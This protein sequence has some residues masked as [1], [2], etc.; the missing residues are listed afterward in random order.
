MIFFVTNPSNVPIPL[1]ASMYISY[2]TAKSEPPLGCSV[3]IPT[4]FNVKIVSPA[5]GFVQTDAGIFVKF[6]PEPKY[7]T[8]VTL[9]CSSTVNPVVPIPT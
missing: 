2:P 5:P 4:S 3:P 1:S 7:S 9:P 8:A 6:A